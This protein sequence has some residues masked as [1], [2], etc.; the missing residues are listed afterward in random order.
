MFGRKPWIWRHFRISSMS[1]ENALNVFY[2]G[3]VS[4]VADEMTFKFAKHTTPTFWKF[5]NT[6]H[7]FICVC[8]FLSLLNYLGGGTLLLTCWTKN[9]VFFVKSF[10]CTLSFSSMLRNYFKNFGFSVWTN[11]FTFQFLFNT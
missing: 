3:G 5:Y 2:R 6:Q 11:F 7:F 8:C 1:L 10:S 9:D 4:R